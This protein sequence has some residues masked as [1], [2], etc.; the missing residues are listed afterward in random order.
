M[1]LFTFDGD[2]IYDIEGIPKM[3]DWS[4]CIFDLDVWDGDM[5]TNFFHPF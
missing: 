1:I 2:P 4:P 5:I 3:K